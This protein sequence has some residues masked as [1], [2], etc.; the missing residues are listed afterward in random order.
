MIVYVLLDVVINLWPNSMEE[1]MM[2]PFFPKPRLWIHVDL[3]SDG[4]I[5]LVVV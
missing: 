1:V 5:D 3:I 2:E 4:I